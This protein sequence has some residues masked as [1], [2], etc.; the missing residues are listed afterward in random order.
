[1]YALTSF[2]CEG[3]GYDLDNRGV[4]CGVDEWVKCG[5][6]RR[7]GH[8]MRMDEDDFKRLYEGRV[9]V[10]WIYRADEYWSEGTGRQ[11]IEYTED[12]LEQEDWRH[13]GQGIEYSNG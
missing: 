5:T 7:S 12:M 13:R 11:R 4:D 6:V 8:V 10:M 3:D 2:C 1:M 9:S